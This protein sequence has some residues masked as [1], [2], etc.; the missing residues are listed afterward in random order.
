M[1]ARPLESYSIGQLACALCARICHL[2]VW[3]IRCA[4]G[5]TR[6]KQHYGRFDSA[7]TTSRLRVHGAKGLPAEMLSSVED[8]GVRVVSLGSL[9]GGQLEAAADNPVKCSVKTTSRPQRGHRRNALGGSVGSN[10]PLMQAEE[11]AAMPEVRDEKV[12]N[13]SDSGNMLHKSSTE[14]DMDVE[15]FMDVAP[16]GSG[17]PRP[18]LNTALWVQDVLDQLADAREE[19][20][21][22]PEVLIDLSVLDEA[23]RDV[24]ERVASDVPLAPL[25]SAAAA[26]AAATAL[27][28]L[29]CAWRGSLVGQ[30]ADDLNLERLSKAFELSFT[31]VG[32]A[33]GAVMAPS[34]NNDQGNLGVLGKQAE[35]MKKTTLHAL[36]EA[37]LATGAHKPTASSGHTLRDPSA[38]LAVVWLRRSLELQTA[39]IKG[40]VR[41]R[42]AGSNLLMSAIVTAAYTETLE[43]FHNWMLKGTMKVAFNAAPSKDAV[44]RN[45]QG[46]YPKSSDGDG[47]GPLFTDLKLVIDA[48]IA[49]MRAMAKPLVALDLDRTA[50]EG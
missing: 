47:F 3:C 28:Q 41:D 1:T 4:S 27:Y 35:K 38:A 21:G 13:K 45:L 39:I 34:V 37:E 26:P 46:K 7:P 25:A 14:Q 49:V 43:R 29:A 5:A 2:I 19:M 40:L 12:L 23:A 24:E 8:D 44:V 16:D 48:Q 20:M 30:D 9:K 15:Y 32:G 18:L 33:I 17:H 11:S 50:K 10:A 42:T 6:G 36:L 22:V 31:V